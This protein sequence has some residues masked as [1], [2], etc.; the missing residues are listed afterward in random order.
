MFGIHP[1]NTSHLTLMSCAKLKVMSL[2]RFSVMD[3]ITLL[4]Q[5]S[6][7]IIVS[8]DFMSFWQGDS[9][10]EVIWIVIDWSDGIFNWVVQHQL[11]QWDYQYIPLGSLQVPHFGSCAMYTST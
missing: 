4:S 5:Q 1:G 6:I 9:G 3:S 10:C 11:L 7:E 8:P 2:C